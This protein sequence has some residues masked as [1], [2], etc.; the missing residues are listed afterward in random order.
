M[1]TPQLI[2][3]LRKAAGISRAEAARGFGVDAQTLRGWETGR[4]APSYALRELVY[5]Y[6][7]LIANPVNNDKKKE[8]GKML[9]TERRAVG[10]TRES[11]AKALDVSLGT[12][13]SWER[14]T[15]LTP[16]YAVRML[17]RYYNSF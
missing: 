1:I 12:I 16:P 8:I 17:L 15:N 5:F 11:V 6:N 10:L 9:L 3:D 13:T 14:G 7:E 4:E 2:L